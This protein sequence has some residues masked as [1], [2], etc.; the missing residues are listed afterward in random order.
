MLNFDIT[1]DA[2]YAGYKLD[3]LL[4]RA[5]RDADAALKKGDIAEVVAFFAEIRELI[6]NLA[7]KTTK[8]T[9]FVETLS[10]DSIP[11]LFTNLNIKTVNVPGV[12][13]VTINNRWSAGPSEKDRERAMQWLRMTGN[14]GLITET[15][16]GNTLGAFA[17]TEALAG[18]P[19]PSDIFTVKTVP[20]VSVTA[21]ESDSGK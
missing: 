3:L 2:E 13:R 6:Q 8:L 7:R 1:V 4:L 19:L 5:T 21:T 20:Y 12:G 10:H 18:R 17:K 11:T 16:N 9:K 14:E 15:V